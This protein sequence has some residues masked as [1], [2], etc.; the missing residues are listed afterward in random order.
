MFT[1]RSRGNQPLV[2]VNGTIYFTP[3]TPVRSGNVSNSFF[4][5][6]FFHLSPLLRCPLSTFHTFLFHRR[7]A[8]SKKILVINRV[9]EGI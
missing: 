3:F 9:A 5:F 7:D 4:F 1:G 2:A 6:F 8:I